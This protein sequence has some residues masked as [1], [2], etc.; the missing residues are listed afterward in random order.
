[1]WPHFIKW[2]II[3]VSVAFMQF[4]PCGCV[5]KLLYNIP[6]VQ[7]S[8]QLKL[9]YHRGLRNKEHFVLKQS[10][11]DHIFTICSLKAVFQLPKSLNTATV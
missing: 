10:A 6:Y 11:I 1:M 9:P 5:R 4:K 2:S 8:S 7:A 3:G